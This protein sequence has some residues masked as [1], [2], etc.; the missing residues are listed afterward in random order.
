MIEFVTE[1]GRTCRAK[2]AV[3]KTHTS[4]IPGRRVLVHYDRAGPSKIFIPGHDGGPAR[5]FAL[6]GAVVLGV[7]LAGLWAF[8]RGLTAE[9]LMGSGAP[10]GAAFQCVGGTVLAVGVAG[11][12]AALRIKTG[13]R[14]RGVVIG[15]TTSRGSQGMTRHHAVVRWTAPT[16][17]VLEAP[18]GQGRLLRRIPVGI[19]I[20]V[21]Q[22]PHAPY[23][24]LLTGDWPEMV[25]FALL[26]FGALCSTVGALVTW[27]VLSN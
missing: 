15:E 2:S 27:A 13:P 8:R 9:D 17:E 24:I 7:G 4:F 16:G 5:V 25:N 12:L 26:L 21:R 18:S 23:R 20:T 6:I 3:S 11:I 10:F 1:D 19:E 14:S 22:H